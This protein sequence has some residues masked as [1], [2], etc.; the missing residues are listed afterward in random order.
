MKATQANQVPTYQNVMEVLVN[1]E[2]NRQMKQ[3]PPKLADYINRVE[4]ATYALNRLPPLYASSQEGRRH[5]RV[6]GKQEYNN[7]IATAVR[8][9]FA[10]VQRDPLRRATPMTREEEAEYQMALAALEQIQQLLPHK[11]LS[12][13]NLVNV[14]QQSLTKTAPRRVHRRALGVGD[15]SHAAV[16]PG[17]GAARAASRATQETPDDACGDT[18]YHW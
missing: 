14:L 11:Q 5:Q 12:W 8:Q 15:P 7:Q 9:A 17:S 13:H 18:R 16:S 1:E 6:R 3:L 4:V 2:V 10:A